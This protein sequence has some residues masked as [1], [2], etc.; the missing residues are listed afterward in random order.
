LISRRIITNIIGGYFEAELMPE[1]STIMATMSILTESIVIIFA[2]ILLYRS[3]SNSL[4]SNNNKQRT[5]RTPRRSYGVCRNNI[6]SIIRQV[7]NLSTV[8]VS[9]TIFAMLSLIAL[10]SIGISSSWTSVGAL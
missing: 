1:A 8:S 10:N 6:S 9:I 2:V 7:M 4:A 5:P 3:C